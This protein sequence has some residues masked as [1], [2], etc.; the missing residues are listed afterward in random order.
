MNFRKNKQEQKLKEIYSVG[1]EDQMAPGLCA[2]DLG[3]TGVVWF[4]TNCA[5]TWSAFPLLVVCPDHL[6]LSLSP[7][8]N[9]ICS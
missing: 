3:N 7:F 9:Y 1:S 2:W 8:I 5:L 6:H 4:G